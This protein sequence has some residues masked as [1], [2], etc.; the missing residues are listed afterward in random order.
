MS[1]SFLA[2]IMMTVLALGMLALYV[3]PTMDEIGKTQDSIVE[4]Q[5]EKARVNEVNA[6]LASMVSRVNQIS[7]ADMTAL[8]TYLPDNVDY[9][10]VSR[11]VYGMA[12][13][14]GIFVNSVKYS[15]THVE[16]QIDGEP[17]QPK[18]HDFSVAFTSSYDQLKV[19]LKKLE[20]SNYPLEVLDFKASVD[21]EG[22][23]STEMTLVTYSHL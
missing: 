9:V 20:Q 10:S 16:T 3:R 21:D 23:I 22:L 5:N 11:D 18:R 17:I 6:K 2:Q 19:F 1:N 14:S 8:L 7:S 15:G 13:S 4:Y 12:E